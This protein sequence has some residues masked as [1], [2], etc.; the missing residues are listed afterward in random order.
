MTMID[1]SDLIKALLKANGS[2]RKLDGAIL[3]TMRPEVILDD[4]ARDKFWLDGLRHHFDVPRYTGSVDV[5][6]GLIREH[7]LWSASCHDH[8]GIPQYVVLLMQ[9]DMKR[10][11]PFFGIADTLALAFCIAALRALTP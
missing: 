4:K 2:D 3:K 1:T 11:D 7:W 10:L 9:P 6:M 5:A 8:D